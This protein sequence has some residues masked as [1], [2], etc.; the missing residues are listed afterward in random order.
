MSDKLNA[1]LSAGIAALGTGLAWWSNKKTRDATQQA[2]EDQ[3]QYNIDMYERQKQDSLANWF[4]QNSYNS[5]LSQMQRFQEAGLNPNLIY[6]SS[7]VSDAIKVGGVGSYNPKTEPHKFDLANGIQAYND[8]IM[9]SAQVDN[10]KVQNDVLIAESKLKEA[11]KNKTVLDTLTSK[12]DL[13]LKSELKENSLDVAKATLDKMK[14]DLLIQDA[15]VPVLESQKHLLDSQTH[16]SDY[17][18]ERAKRF[19]P[20]EMQQKIADI[21]KT[22]AGIELTHTQLQNIMADTDNKKIQKSIYEFE[23]GLKELQLKYRNQGVETNDPA[24]LRLL[25]QFLN[26]MGIEAFAPPVNFKDGDI[27]VYLSP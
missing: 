13:D 12:F 26:S 16:A 18:T 19:E 4:M 15:Q 24:Y 20:L 11:Q 22:H 21:A 14:G 3:K 7:N 17:N 25:S 10:L 9:R 6:G 5:P 27:P 1:W 2:N 23:R 8:F